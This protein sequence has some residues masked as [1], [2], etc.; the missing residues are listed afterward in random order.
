MDSRHVHEEFLNH[1][2]VVVL[3]KF[4][5]AVE[6]MDST[7]MFPSRLMDLPVADIMTSSSVDAYVENNMDLKGFYLMVK[8]MKIQL[9]EGSK[10]VDENGEH[11]IPLERELKETL[12]RLNYFHMTAKYIII[13]AQLLVQHEHI[14]SFLEFEAN[15]RNSADDCLLEGI[16]KFIYEV[17]EM[18][19]AVLFPCLLK[20]R[21]V[22]EFGFHPPSDGVLQ[23]DSIHDVFIML[24]LLKAEL[25][26]GSEDMELADR[27]LQQKLSDLSRTFRSY[28]TM[29]RN[30]TARYEQEVQ[31]Y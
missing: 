13:C 9:A 23:A 1:S 21:T 7:V 27:K 8:A 26:S 6:A 22:A 17:E 20:D 2:F 30:L 25:L 14:P 18:E 3:E 29:T 15:S 19:R 24:K 5:Q 16:K 4:I 10:H 11:N 28:T 31:C 12:Q